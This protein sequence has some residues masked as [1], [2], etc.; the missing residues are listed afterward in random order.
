MLD[1]PL[2][3]QVS[4]YTYLCS[5]KGTF[6]VRADEEKPDLLR[7][8]FDLDY[9]NFVILATVIGRYFKESG[10]PEVIRE[11]VEAFTETLRENVLGSAMRR[12]YRKMEDEGMSGPCAE[13]YA[14]CDAHY[15]TLH[16]LLRLSFNSAIEKIR[17][18]GGEEA[19]EVFNDIMENAAQ[20]CTITVAQTINPREWRMHFL[21]GNT[22]S[23]F[24]AAVA[25]AG[26]FN[27]ILTPAMKAFYPLFKA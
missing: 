17:F 7:F 13:M 18:H 22:R 26:L 15:I 1:T 12:F 6:E 2:I 21:F 16:D 10:H 14:A 5:H 25:T 24:F 20:K 4:V 9:Y 23:L 8:S 19:V 27:N 11:G 3:D